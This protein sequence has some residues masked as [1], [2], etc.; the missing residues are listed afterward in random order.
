MA[1]IQGIAKEYEVENTEIKKMLGLPVN[2]KN[3]RILGVMEEKKV[4]Q[5]LSA[6]DDSRDDSEA[7]EKKMSEKRV[8]WTL[9]VVSVVFLLAVLSLILP[10]VYWSMNSQASGSEDQLAEIMKAQTEQQAQLE[11]LEEWVSTSEA[12]GI[13]GVSQAYIKKTMS[14]FEDELENLSASVAALNENSDQDLEDQ[15]GEPQESESQESDA[16]SISEERVARLMELDDVYRSQGWRQWLEA[17]GVI[18]DAE[19]EA[20]QP[21]EETII[22]QGET[23]IVVSGIQV[24]GHCEVPYPA[25]VTTGDPSVITTSEDTQQYQPDLRN[26]SVIYTNVELDGDGTIWVDATN[27][28]QLDPQ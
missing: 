1:T 2:T 12:A 19:V 14:G 8:N 18:C 20:R 10:F 23:R 9:I 5:S 11:S 24:D 7:E 3:E 26:P 15:N 17:A 21:E 25:I 22:Y 28:S 27:W 4:R 6:E 16:S 13:D